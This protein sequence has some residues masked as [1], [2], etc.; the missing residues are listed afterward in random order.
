MI[1]LNG[2][3]PDAPNWWLDAHEK[4]KGVVELRLMHPD[5]EGL[6]VGHC[7]APISEARELV[8]AGWQEL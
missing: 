2:G 5:K 6:E 4:A 7:F 3:R 8:A 1:R